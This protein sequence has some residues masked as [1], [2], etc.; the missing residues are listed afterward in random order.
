VA[1]WF[2]VQQKQARLASL[3]EIGAVALGWAFFSLSVRHYFS[4][5]SLFKDLHDYAEFGTYSVLWLGYGALL[6]LFAKRIDRPSLLRLGQG[7]FFLALAFTVLM[8]GGL[9]NPLWAPLRVGSL[10]LLNAVLFSLGIPALFALHGMRGPAHGH[11]QLM[12]CSGFAALWL[13]FLTVSL[14]LRQFFHLSRL[15]R[16]TT[17][18]TELY[19]YSA[20]WVVFGTVLLIVG[21]WRRSTLLRFASLAV[22]LVAVGKVFLFDFSHLG[23]L[24]RVFSFLGLGV[25]LLVLAFLYQRFVFR[26]TGS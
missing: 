9:A 5:Q 13:S 2:F 15:D 17:S 8:T 3:N 19:A 25:S 16:G 4:P 1:A 14:E 12:L 18:L 6:F 23:G 24:Y 11:K 21:I 10:P 26:E 7:V 22:M 20:V